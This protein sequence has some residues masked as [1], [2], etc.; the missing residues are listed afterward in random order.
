MQL[1]YACTHKLVLVHA[2]PASLGLTGLGVADIITWSTCCN[3]ETEDED[4][5]LDSTETVSFVLD[6]EEGFTVD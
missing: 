6:C 3:S 1:S 4:V 2:S 5:G